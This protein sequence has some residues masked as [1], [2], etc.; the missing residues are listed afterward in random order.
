M[1]AQLDIDF[2]THLRENNAESQ[3]NLDANRD[4]FTKKCREVYNLLVAGN[5]LTV[6]D[7]ANA[8]IAS[9][10]RRILDLKERGV[11]IHDEWVDGRKVYFMH[12]AHRAAHASAQSDRHALSVELVPADAGRA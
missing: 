1:N 7:C 8:G 9:L 2:A 11:P 6:L 3:A 12:A 4:R 10:P 5:R